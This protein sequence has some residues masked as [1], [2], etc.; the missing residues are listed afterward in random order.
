MKQSL[1]AVEAPRAK[2]P[3][4]DEDDALLYR[5]EPTE[6]NSDLVCANC[7]RELARTIKRFT[8]CDKCGADH[9]WRNPK[10]RRNEYLCGKCHAESGDGVVLN[11]WFP[12]VSEPLRVREREACLERSNNSGT[13]CRGEVKPRGKNAVPLCNRHAGKESWADSFRAGEAE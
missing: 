7:V 4:C 1:A 3:R 12:R 11:K 9:A 13:E 10:H 2:C 5:A 8:V 6:D